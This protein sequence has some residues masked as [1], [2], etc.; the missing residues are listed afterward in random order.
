MELVLRFEPEVLRDFEAAA[1]FGFEAAELRDLEAVALFGFDAALLF[2]LEAAV[3]CFDAALLFGFDP[4]VLFGRLA[5][6]PLDELCRPLRD[7]VGLLVAISTH[8]IIAVDV[9]APTLDGYPAGCPAN[10]AVPV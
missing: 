8:L 5:D 4:A 10:Q 3:F 9:P 2:D 7:V 6:A 1:L